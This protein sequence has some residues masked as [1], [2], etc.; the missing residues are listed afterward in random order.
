MPCLYGK[1]ELIPVLMKHDQDTFQ[2]NLKEVAANPIERPGYRIEF[3][4]DF[5]GRSLSVEKWF[6]YYTPQW[7][8]REKSA[9][10]FEVAD[11]VLQLQ[12]CEDQKPWCPEHDGEIRVSSLQTGCFSGPKGSKIGQHRFNPDLVVTE[13]QEAIRLYTPTYGYFETRLKAIPIPG[14]MVAFWMIGFEEKGDDSGEICIC[15]IFGDQINSTSSEIGYG[16]HPQKDPRIKDEFF[17]H[18]L[19]IDASK[20]HIYAAEWSPTKV[21]FYIDNQHVRTIHQSPNYPMQFML[22]VYELP[23]LLQP[24]KL[25]PWPKVFEVD[26]VRAYQPITGY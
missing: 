9:A 16:L 6:P 24:S 15:E 14:Y 10:R 17:K 18:Q 26:Y 20:F 3:F 25:T 8:S 11:G 1:M 22:G 23:W 2:S 4:D 12:I 19:G 13:A 21:D 5:E 7:S